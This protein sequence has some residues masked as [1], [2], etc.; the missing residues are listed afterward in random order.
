M[1]PFTT[2]TKV[3]PGDKTKAY[4]VRQNVC[5]KILLFTLIG[6]CVLLMVLTST[7][8]EVHIERKSKARETG[9]HRREEHNLRL[10]VGRLG[11]R[12][13]Q[14]MHDEV[15]DMSILREYRARMYRAVGE[16]QNAVRAAVDEPNLPANSTLR[17]SLT[18]LEL[19]LDEQLELAMRQLWSDVNAEGKRANEKLHNLTA[20][21]IHSMKV[22]Q[23]GC[24]QHGTAWAGRRAQSFVAGADLRATEAC[25]A[26]RVAAGRLCW[27]RAAR[28]ACAQAVARRREK[29]ARH[30]QDKGRARQGQ[31]G[32][33]KPEGMA[34]AESARCGLAACVRALERAPAA[35]ESQRAQPA[36]TAQPYPV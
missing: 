34:R 33:L 3:G 27:A 8:Y 23:V 28:A 35:T 18:K 17:A 36:L 16:Y 2:L 14:H 21:I 12:L 19:E 25:G 1:L 6:I 31:G 9:A 11:M 24:A 5:L 4:V 32:E 10:Q 29:T 7:M 22:D 13:Q 30:R 15:R 20:E 26:V